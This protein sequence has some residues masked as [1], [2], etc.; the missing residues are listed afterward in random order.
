MLFE[1]YEVMQREDGAPRELGRGATGI[2]YQAWDSDLQCEVILQ[3]IS[4]SLLGTREE[5]ERCLRELRAMEQLRLKGIATIFRVGVTENHGLY[6]AMEYCEGPTLEQAIKTD[7]LFPAYDAL[8]IAGQVTEALVTAETLGLR[9]G[10]L[11]PSNLV[12]TDNPED[13]KVVKLINFGLAR[14]M[15]EG[16]QTLTILGSSGLVDTAYFASPEQLEERERLDI[17]SDIYSLGACLWYALS[18]HPPFQGPLAVAMSRTLF[19]ELPWE[20]LAAQPKPV[21]ALLKRMLAKKP[22]DRPPSAAELCDEI[23]HCLSLVAALP[24]VSERPPVVE[25]APIPPLAVRFQPVEEIS[26]DPTGRV[27]RAIH[28]ANKGAPVRYWLIDLGLTTVPATWRELQVQ[29]TTAHEHPHPHFVNIVTAET[30]D[31]GLAIVQEYIKGFSLFELMESRRRLLPTDALPILRQ[32]ASAV[33]YAASCGVRGLNLDEKH[34]FVH[35]P[36]SSGDEPFPDLRA[37]PVN[38]WPRYEIKADV[39]S[40][41]ETGTMIPGLPPHT[42]EWEVAALAAL[43]CELLGG[44]RGHEFT[45]IPQLN[46]AANHVLFSACTTAGAFPGGEALVEA[47]RESSERRI[48]APEPPPFPPML[49]PPVEPQVPARH[50]PSEPSPSLRE[51]ELAAPLK[52]GLSRGLIVTVLLAVLVGSG[53]GYYVYQSHGANRQHPADEAVATQPVVK[54]PTQEQPAPSHPTATPEPVNAPATTK[55]EPAVAPPPVVTPQANTGEIVATDD[56]EAAG[57]RVKANAGDIEAARKLGLIYLDGRGV[58][59]NAAEALKWLQ[60]ATDHDDAEAETALGTMYFDGWGV[61]KDYYRAMLLHRKAADQGNCHGLNRLGAMY[62]YGWGV[63]R[64]Y[65]RA[66]ELIQKSANQGDPGG[67]ASLG[68]MYQIGVGTEQDYSQ[69]LN[70]FQK[71]ADQGNAMGQNGMGML[72]LGGLGLAKDYAEAFIYFQKAADQGNVFAEANIGDMY[73]NGWALPKDDQEA[74]KWY[75][76][77][78]AQGDARATLSIKKLKEAM[79][80][81]AQVPA[82][83]GDKSP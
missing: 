32:L 59:K 45:P 49:P 47:L 54:Q 7:G 61:E 2:T 38:Q 42:R 63:P 46:A 19:A 22:A 20:N 65:D 79:G 27:F 5:L 50:I 52:P 73:A 34:V 81:N 10:D 53:L 35:F 24:Q 44:Q 71:A 17:R 33:D 39:I 3:D 72:Y 8:C 83:N 25:E 62:A 70:W 43:A 66:F 21:I 56:V 75:Q 13:G 68:S 6:C 4:P 11:K 58:P 16:R 64:D 37:L 18:G 23:E 14:S 51:P 67:E 82:G 15:S 78:A 29:I 41:V 31:D 12:F 80:G 40:L 76:K 77:A 9:H 74:L 48:P 69:A 28:H 26:H 55:P 36:D 60:L 1:H 30:T 57:Y